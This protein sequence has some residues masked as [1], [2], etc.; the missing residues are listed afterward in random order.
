MSGRH[1]S[2]TEKVRRMIRE[3]GTQGITVKDL[4]FEL[5]RKYHIDLV[6][7]AE[8]EK[9]YRALKDLWKSGEI[10]RISRGLYCWQRT[11]PPR[12]TKKNV[13]WDLVRSDRKT[14]KPTKIGDLAAQ[15]GV[16][17]G[18]AKKFM[19]A[20]VRRELVRRIRPGVYRL[21]SD[22]VQ[23]PAFNKE[24]A[25]WRREIRARKQAAQEKLAAAA[26]AVKQAQAA[27]AAIPE[28]PE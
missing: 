13:M 2:F 19:A 17:R 24:K 16:T 5:D 28:P 15:A 20:L 7:A 25:A 1:N 11:I 12:V 10:R 3:Y 4:C 26:E 14:G 8:K 21:I 18:Y 9:I 27:L 22:P 6:T 23:M